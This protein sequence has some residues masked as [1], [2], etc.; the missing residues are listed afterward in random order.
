MRYR[1]FAR[2]LIEPELLH[3]RFAFANAAVALLTSIFKP[4][5]SNSNWF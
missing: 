3:T 2:L 4:S 5:R 1:N